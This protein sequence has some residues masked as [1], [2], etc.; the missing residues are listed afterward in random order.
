MVQFTEGKPVAHVLGNHIEQ[1]D[2]P[3]IDYPVGI[4]YQPHE[5]TF[6][7]ARAHLLELLAALEQMK[8]KPVKLALRDFTITP[9]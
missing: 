3:F 8:D 6:E 7:L 1:T 2:M 9:K 5:H 4:I